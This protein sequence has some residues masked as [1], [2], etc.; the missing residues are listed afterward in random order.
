MADGSLVEVEPEPV[1][2]LRGTVVGLEGSAVAAS[3]E[4]DGLHARIFLSEDEQYW[5]EPVA[6]RVPRAGPNHYV[7]YDND[8]I[9]APQKTCGL[10]ALEIAP[11]DRGASG[12]VR[13]TR[14]GACGTGL[15]I[16]EL[17]VDAD[18]EYYQDYNSSVPDVTSRIDS[19]INA[20]NVQYE[21][22]VDITHVITTIIIRTA[23]PDPYTHTD[24]TQLLFQ[25]RS[26]WLANHGNVQ[27]D[28]VQLFT[29]RS[30]AGS[31]IG[32]AWLD[33]ICTDLG[34]SV[35]QS[36]YNGNFGCTTDLTAHELGHNWGADHCSCST[37]TMNKRTRRSH[38]P[39]QVLLPTLHCMH[40]L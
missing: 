30:L 1:R 16:S 39:D 31:T 2:T 7:I 35:V 3:L 32:I 26:H 24:A 13:H 11:G 14:A 9:I 12:T 23:E 27:R 4:A 8:D 37:Y 20:V 19:V 10:D 22:D 17:A 40:G 28:T 34:F 21:R 38:I 5:L 29:G 15:C 36:D 33:A 25:F 6:S 18:F